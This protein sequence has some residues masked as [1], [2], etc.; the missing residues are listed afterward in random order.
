MWYMPNRAL[1]KS[2]PELNVP[3]GEFQNTTGKRNKVGIQCNKTLLV[4]LAGLD[5]TQASQNFFKVRSALPFPPDAV[6]SASGFMYVYARIQDSSCIP[7]GLLKWNF[8]FG[9]CIMIV[10]NSVSIN[11][12]NCDASLE[13]S[14]SGIDFHV[15]SLR[16]MREFL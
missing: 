14:C 12:V 2:L 4:F 5:F 6:P 1:N 11:M 16:F 7:G 9:T 13:A 15:P 8:A 10:H 3:K